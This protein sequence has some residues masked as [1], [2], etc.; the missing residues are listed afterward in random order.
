MVGIHFRVITD[1]IAVRATLLKRDLVPRIARW[2]LR[3]QVFDMEVAYRA[4]GRML[5]VDA[6]SRNPLSESGPND[7]IASNLLSLAEDDWFLTVQMQDI[8]AKELLAAAFL[9]GDTDLG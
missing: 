5:H 2:W 6:L 7:V 3:L 4:G 1:C 8:K 9:A